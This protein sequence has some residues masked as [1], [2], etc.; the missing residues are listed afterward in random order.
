MSI[1]SALS[2]ALSGLTAASRAAQLVSSNVANVATD[3]YGR[4]ELE[5][6]ARATT[7]AGDGVQIDGIR[8]VVDAALLQDRRVA[9][10]AQGEAELI[11]RFF[12][13]AADIFGRPDDP[14]A[15]SARVDRFE[16]SLIDAASRPD[17][18]ARLSAVVNAA[19]DLTEGLKTAADGIQTLRERADTTIGQTVT[20]LNADLQRVVDLNDAILQARGSGQDYPALLDQRQVVIDRIAKVVPLTSIPR[21]NDTVALYTTGGTRLVDLTAAEIEFNATSPITADM[22][23][24][25]GALSGLSIDGQPLRLS[26]GNSAIAGGT[27]AALFQIRDELAPAAQG[28]LD[29]LAGDLV[30]RFEDPTLDPTRAPGAPGIFTDNGAAFDPLNTEGLAQRISVNDLVRPE[31]GGDLWRI[32]DGLGAVAPGPAGASAL[33]SALQ[34]T[35]AEARTPTDPALGTAARSFAGLVAERLSTLTQSKVDSESDLAFD[36]ARYDALRSRELANGVDTDQEMQKL[37]LIEQ[38]YAAN[39]QVVR[40]ASQL[41]DQLLEI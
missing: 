37:L 8:R 17:S 16:T 22:S 25:S 29:A 19:V 13:D 23:L 11:S 15:L 4:R 30:S 3:G 34:S 10:A 20:S 41:I 9:E 28:D 27:L 24:A 6:S 35:L 1:S 36:A 7:G 26:G 39:A 38:A 14:G 21:E 31:A 2:N 5:L 12:A 32:R 18:S 40:T 33:L